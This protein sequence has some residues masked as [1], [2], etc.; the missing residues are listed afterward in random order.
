MKYRYRVPEFEAL[1]LDHQASAGL[2]PKWFSEAVK[3]G[4]IYWSGQ[5]YWTIAADGARRPRVGPFDWIILGEAG[6]LFSMSDENFRR[7]LV[8]LEE[9]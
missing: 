4:S 7:N 3:R 2:E 8:A 6:E 1:Q 9:T 5:G